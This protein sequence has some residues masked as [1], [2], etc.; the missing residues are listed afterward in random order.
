MSSSSP[1]QPRLII[2]M[3]V[4]GAGKSTIGEE[5]A[6]RLEVPFIDADNLH[7]RANVEKMRGGRPLEDTDRWPWLEI[8]ADAMRN[9]ADTNGRVVCACSALRRSYRDCLRNRAEEPIAF[10]LLHGDK[11]VIAQ[12]QANRPGHFMPPAL[13]D[14][15]FATLEQ[16]GPQERGITIDVALSIDEIV[17]EAAAALS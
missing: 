4:S 8:V 7:P 9:T 12:R 10:V 14:S 13:L 2:V 16:F 1:A 17:D 3:G 5:L 11:S 15:Q 6:K